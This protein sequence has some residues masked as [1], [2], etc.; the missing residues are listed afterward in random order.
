MTN[1]ERVALLYQ[2][3]KDWLTAVAFNFTQDQNRAQDL[4]QDVYLYLLEMKDL[5]KI[6]YSERD[7]NLYY[8][9]QLIR[10]KYL[11]G[12]KKKKKINI[13]PLEEEY[14]ENEGENEYDE[15]ADAN[16]E[17][18]LQI[19]K[20]GLEELHWFDKKLFETYHNEGHSIS[21]LHEATKIS[22]NTIW[23]SLSKTKKY[24]KQKAKDNEN[25]CH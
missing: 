6:I 9:Y 16:T 23:Q 22:R 4:L 3:H 12:I 5:E 1:G 7:L 17:R 21:S 8:I 14:L 15:Q 24:I 13:T 10:S 11:N 18:L 25:L 2:K 19:I 20:E